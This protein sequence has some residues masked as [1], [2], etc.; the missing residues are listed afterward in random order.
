MFSGYIVYMGK[1]GNYFDYISFVVR[2]IY[3][4]IFYK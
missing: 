3:S 2:Y 4:V 1:N